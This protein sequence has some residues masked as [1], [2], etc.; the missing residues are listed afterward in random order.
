MSLI[1]KEMLMSFVD[2]MALL[3]A[4]IFAVSLLQRKGGD[5]LHN[6][7]FMGLLFSFALVMSM[8]DPIHLPND[9]G[10][11]DMRALLV[12]TATAILGPVVG[13]MTLVTGVTYR[14]Y[15]GGAG[16]APGI[17]GMCAVFVSGWIWR[18]FVKDLDIAKIRKSIIL[19][20]LL[21][22]QAAAFLLTPPAVTQVLFPSLFPYMLVSSLA[23]AV[24]IHSLLTGEF[25]YISEA[26]ASLIHANTDHLTGLL[27]RRGLDLAYDQM[28]QREGRRAGQ[29][30]LYF[31]V[32]RFKT[33][34][35]TY[36]HAV[37]DDLLKHIV[38][39]ISRNLRM[40]DIFVRLGGDE[41]VVILPDIDAPEAEKIAERCREV[42]SAANFDVA[43][44]ILP[45]S[46]SVGA[47]WMRAP[48]EVDKMLD[49]ADRALYQA[50][51]KG[52]NA[53]VFLSGLRRV[54]LIHKAA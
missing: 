15:I 6:T 7:T 13:A 34:N 14:M 12:G 4:L 9:A 25:T 42:V 24:L 20:L 41:F 19:G 29:A 32:D 37:G 17:L 11:F 28:T 54:D 36:G 51:A 38:S 48:T 22:S 43:G 47:V 10:I 3:M 44:H 39:M 49:A 52:R 40:D 50:K 8:S 1:F 18:R 27:N 26:Q 35:D 5:A 45:V 16:V 30:L 46:I 31:D 2:S 23:G 33:T 53:V 21:S